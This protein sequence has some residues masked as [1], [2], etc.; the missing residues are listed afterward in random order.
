MLS[1]FISVLIGFSSILLSTGNN[2][3]A[4]GL[5]VAVERDLGML[6]RLAGRA[7]DVAEAFWSILTSL[8]RAPE[9]LG[10][11]FSAI[12][13]SH[14]AWLHPAL[15]FLVAAGISLLVLA[16]PAILDQLAAKWISHKLAARTRFARA[17]RLILFDVI[18]F[19]LAVALGF[20]LVDLIFRRQFLIGKF[21]VTLVTAAMRW[22][23]TM[24]APEILLRPR[25]AD[26]RLVPVDDVRAK[27]AMR[28]IGAVLALGL[29]F[30][31]VVPV[32]LEAGLPMMTAQ[33]L[34][35][36]V[37]TLMAVGG[38]YGVSRFF[39]GMH[40]A[41][42]F[43]ANLLV[44]LLWLAWSAGV[45]MLDFTVYHGVVWTVGIIAATVA[46][47]RLLGLA[48]DPADAAAREQSNMHLLMISTLRRSVLA[49]AGTLVAGLTARLWLVDIIGIV[50][51][52]TWYHV[53]EAVFTALAVLVLGYIGYQIFHAW[54]EAKFG[55]QHAAGP[56][57]LDDDDAM[58]ASRLSSVLPVLRGVLGGLIVGTAV[59]LA[60]SH[61][62]INV[63]PLIAGAGIFGLAIS[64]G[65]QALVRDIVA[66]LFYMFD[67]AF[68]VGEYIAAGKYKGTVERIA[69]RSVRLRHQNGQIHTIPYGQLGAVTNFSRDYQT[70]KFNLRLARDTDVE[71]VRKLAK[72]LGQQMMSDAELGK[73]FLQPFK[74]QGVAD[75]QENALVL[76]FKFTARPTRPTLVQ[77]E[78]LKRLY[79]LFTD[80]GI[81]FASN[82]V[83]VQTASGAPV[84]SQASA[85]QIAASVASSPRPS[86][87][88]R[89]EPAS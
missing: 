69:L 86:S 8:S 23:L 89:P 25:H 54:T 53:R 4:Q 73:E 42:G 49:I 37:G 3:A 50:N 46:V 9:D 82:A 33:A 51:Y 6:A 65:S 43:T 61:L 77:R 67:D 2:A 41:A 36:V 31:S 56:R 71:K 72:K 78:V 39:S 88:P 81:A 48:A 55:P 79:R 11:A 70:I 80:E 66:G 27:F 74:M 15:P 45:M 58:P 18:A 16:V 22:R 84:D 21:A 10:A 62:G 35:L 38:F 59:L 32:L 75:I 64:F 85:A 12:M 13:S 76:R 29:L 60:L 1:R 44:L 20:L 68:R 34:A 40:G 30:I 19:L 24:L 5:V 47:D 17:F 83:L 14:P 63:A 87:E 7:G 28:V 26:F 57:S 52:E